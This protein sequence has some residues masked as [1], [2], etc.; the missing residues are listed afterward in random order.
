MNQ[1]APQIHTNEHKLSTNNIP[2]ADQRTEQNRTKLNKK[3]QRNLLANP[4]ANQQPEI[5]SLFKVLQIEIQVQNNDFQIHTRKHTRGIERS[6]TSFFP[7]KEGPF[8]LVR[9]L[10]FP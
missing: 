6:N 3:K 9:F 4:L 2:R 1:N 5:D 8:D 7:V 10:V